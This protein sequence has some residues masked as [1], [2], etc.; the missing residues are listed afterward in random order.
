MS[1]QPLSEDVPFPAIQDVNQKIKIKVENVGKGR[2]GDQ[3]DKPIH[4]FLF[5]KQ[6]EREEREEKKAIAIYF[7]NRLSYRERSRFLNR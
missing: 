5:R 3:D 6:S 4:S 2:K 1:R 7:S